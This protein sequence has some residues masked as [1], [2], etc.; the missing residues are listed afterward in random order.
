MN[1]NPVQVVVLA[2]P[3]ITDKQ[4]K[5]R[6]MRSSLARQLVRLGI[7]QLLI[8]ILCIIFQG[9]AV[10]IFVS[11]RYFGSVLDYIGH[12]FWIGIMVSIKLLSNMDKSSFVAYDTL[13]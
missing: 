3:G 10:W 12:G 7:L 13:M 5:Y 1:T 9:V 11:E 2:Q 8:G 6:N 4:V